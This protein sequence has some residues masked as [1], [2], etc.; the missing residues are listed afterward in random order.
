MLTSPGTKRGPSTSESTALHLTDKAPTSTGHKSAR[1]TQSRTCGLCMIDNVDPC[2]HTTCPGPIFSMA[3][4]SQRAMVRG[5][6][7]VSTCSTSRER[8][9]VVLLD[10]A[11]AFVAVVRGHCARRVFCH[12][13]HRVAS[14]GKNARDVPAGGLLWLPLRADTATSFATS[15][16]MTDNTCAPTRHARCERARPLM[17]KAEE[18]DRRN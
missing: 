2:P 3:C 4:A 13:T 9:Q 11:G 16:T 5:L 1:R 7:I 10:Y 12:S 14:S 18:G 15:P 17:Q 8:L 6:L